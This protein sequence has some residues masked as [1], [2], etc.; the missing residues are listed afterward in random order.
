MDSEGK[1]GLSYGAKTTPHMFIITPDGNVAYAGAID[2]DRSVGTL[3]KTN[4]VLHALH[5]LLQGDKV[6]VAE[7]AP[8][9]CSV[10]YGK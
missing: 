3:G 1:V 9:G 10:K 7:T 4:H 6:K 8:Y 2:D 5:D